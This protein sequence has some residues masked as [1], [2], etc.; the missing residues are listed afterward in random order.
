VNSPY[1]IDNNPDAADYKS[2]NTKESSVNHLPI[3]PEETS[4]NR[5]MRNK[6]A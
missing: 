6:P 5:F 2:N 4:S 3:V 1:N